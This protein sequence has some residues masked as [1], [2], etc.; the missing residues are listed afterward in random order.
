MS[1]ALILVQVL[2]PVIYAAEADKKTV[3]ESGDDKEESRA[4]RGGG[5][6][7]GGDGMWLYLSNCICLCTVAIVKH[8]L[9]HFTFQPAESV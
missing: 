1:H 3:I 5:D 2:C 6:D 8:S 4:E 9:S 7:D